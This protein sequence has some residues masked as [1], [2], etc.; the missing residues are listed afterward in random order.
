MRR[1]HP[2]SD[3]DTLAQ[4]LTGGRP[5]G[6]APESRQEVQMSAADPCMPLFQYDLFEADSPLVDLDAERG[7]DFSPRRPFGWWRL[8]GL[9]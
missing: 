2:D 3:F 6:P 8:V 5:Q 7:A 4:R 1:G 9:Q